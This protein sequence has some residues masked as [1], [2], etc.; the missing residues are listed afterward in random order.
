MINITPQI[1]LLLL[2]SLLMIVACQP[3]SNLYIHYRSSFD[4]ITI[5]KGR[6]TYTRFKHY[7]SPDQPFRATPDSIR[8]EVV[9]RRTLTYIPFPNY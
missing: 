2:I 4:E 1:A 3:L 9:I 5:E 8:S 6:L 7:F